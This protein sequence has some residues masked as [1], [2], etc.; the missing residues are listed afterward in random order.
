M[1]LC[2]ERVLPPTAHPLSQKPFNWELQTTVDKIKMRFLIPKVI[3]LADHSHIF[4]NIE[5]T[6][7][8]GHIMAIQHC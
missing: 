4:R 7:Y 3:I 2:L 8:I 1:K 5:E 6:E